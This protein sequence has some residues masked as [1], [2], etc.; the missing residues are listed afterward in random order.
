M[1]LCSVFLEIGS[2]GF[3]MFTSV[4]VFILLT[5]GNSTFSS[6]IFPICLI[7]FAI[8]LRRVSKLEG[9]KFFWSK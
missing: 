5:S 8:F 7:G 1:G 4:Y 9:L 6:W 3:L 2:E